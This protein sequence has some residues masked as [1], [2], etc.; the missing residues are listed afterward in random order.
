M[1]DALANGHERIQPSAA[2]RGLGSWRDVGQ[3][4]RDALARRRHRNRTGVRRFTTPTP[5]AE[6]LTRTS[7]AMA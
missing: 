5:P 3:V 2:G 1:A 7:T 6:T 4:F